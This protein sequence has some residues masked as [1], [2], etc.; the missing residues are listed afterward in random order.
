[1][2][3]VKKNM[4]SIIFLLIILLAIM[5]ISFAWMRVLKTGSNVSFIRA[6]DLGDGKI[7]LIDC[8]EDLTLQNAV[9]ISTKKGLAQEKYCKVEID[10][11]QNDVDLDY[12]IYLDDKDIEST[13]ERML[14]KYVRYSFV[15]DND[16]ETAEK[17]KLLS[18]TGSNP[19]RAI[20]TDT[21]N[22]KQKKVYNLKIWIDQDATNEVMNTIFSGKLRVEITQRRS[23]YLSIDPN[24]GTYKNSKSIISEKLNVGETKELETPVYEGYKFKGWEI[25][26]KT[27]TITNNTL[28][29]GIGSTT[30][31][32]KWDI[33]EEC[34]ARINNKYYITLEKALASA[35]DNDTITMIKNTT[36]SVRNTKNVTIDLNGF[37]ITGKDSTTITNDG[38]L[39]IIGTGKIENNTGVVIENKNDLTLGK[40]DG[41]VSITN[42]MLNGNIGIKQ[43]GTLN[44][45]DGII[46]ANVGISGPTTTKP[47]DYIVFVDHDNSSDKQKVYLINI[48]NT[49]A[50][51]MLDSVLYMNLQ[52]AINTAE[53]LNTKLPINIIRDCELAYTLTVKKDKNVVIDLDGNKIS[54]GYTITNNGNLTLKD[55]SSQRGVMKPSVTITNNGSLELNGIDLA[56]T[57]SANVIDNKNSLSIIN[58]NITGLDGYAINNS[59]SILNIDDAS[60][61]IANK[62]SL[63]NDYENL[64][65]KSGNIKG[66]YTNNSLTIDGGNIYND[67][68]Q[69]IYL[70]KGTLIVNDG[71]ISNTGTHK[72]ITSSYN[73]T[74]IKILGGNISSTGENTVEAQSTLEIYSGTIKNTNKDYS[75]IITYFSPKVY[76]YGGTIEAEGYGIRTGNVTVNGG[77][78]SGKICGASFEGGTS[79]INGGTI[80]SD[81]NAV[82][83]TYGSLTVNGGTLYG[84]QYG[85]SLEKSN[86]TLNLGIDDKNVNTTS[87]VVRGDTYGIYSSNAIFNYYDGII[88]GQ[89]APYYGQINAITDGYEIKNDLESIDGV[90]YQTSYLGKKQDFVSV[91]EETFNSLQKAID[92]VEDTAVLKII[93]EAS[94][95][96]SITIPETK[97]ITLDL[98]GNNISITQ[99]ITNN[100]K[101]IIKDS[102]SSGSLVSSS[103]DNSIISNGPLTIENGVIKRINQD[104]KKT[105]IKMNSGDFYLKDGVVISYGEVIHGN[106]NYPITI[107]GGTISEKGSSTAIYSEG[108]IKV[109]SGIITTDKGGYSIW[110]NNIEINGGTMNS[111]V[112]SNGDLTIND[113]E[114]TSSDTGIDC[115]GTTIINGGSIYGGKFG[116]ALN[117]SKAIITGGNITSDVTAIFARSRD[118]TISGGKIYGKKYGIDVYE[119]VINIGKDDS[120]INRDTPEI[121]GDVYG[122]YYESGKVN[123][124]DGI[125]K[126]KTEAY[127]GTINKTAEGY[128]LKDDTEDI[129]GTVYKTS[130]LDKQP[131]YV[132]VGEKQFNSLQDAI[133]SVQS[134]GTLEFISNAEIKSEITIP[135]DKNITLD[136]AGY[137]ANLTQIINN[138]GTFTIKDS[139]G[140]GKLV[141]Y[142][143]TDFIISKGNLYIESGTVQRT[144]NNSDKYIIDVENGTF[145]MKGGTVLAETKVSCIKIGKNVSSAKINGGTIR[146]L[147]GTAIY[148]SATIEV[149]D[150]YIISQFGGSTVFGSN[151]IINGGELTSNNNYTIYANNV[152]ITG[153]K[154]GVIRQG[155]AVTTSEFNMTGGLITAPVGIGGANN[156]ISGGKIDS[157]GTALDIN[158]GTLEVTDCEILGT[159]YGIKLNR[160]TLNIGKNDGNINSSLPLIKGNTYGVYITGGNFNFY[161]GIIKGKT[162]AYYGAISSLADNSIISADTE[163]IDDNTYIINYLKE[164]GNIIKNKDS[165][166]NNLQTAI[167]NAKSG[168][169]LQVLDNI[170]LHYPVTISKDD[171]ITIDLAGHNI[172]LMKQLNNLGQ[173]NI[174]S[175]QS[176]GNIKVLNSMESF[177]NNGN[178]QISNVELNN[179]LTKESLINN[180]ENASLNLDNVT[181][182]GK[183]GIKI[184]SNSNAV[185]NNTNT[186]LE[187]ANVYVSTGNLSLTGGT[188]ITKNGT[189][190]YQSGTDNKTIVSD[191]NIDA[192]AS[193]A[194]AISNNG[195]TD[196]ELT[197][198]DIKGPISSS[199]RNSNII[200]DNTTFSGKISVDSNSLVTLKNNSVIKT[201]SDHAIN[202]S[203]TLNLTNSKI[204]SDFSNIQNSGSIKIINNTGTINATNFDTD[205]Y[206]MNQD[207]YGIYN[208]KGTVNLNNYNLNITDNS[209]NRTLY[210]L[211]NTET[212]KINFLTGNI[213]LIGAKL[214]YGLYINN[215]E[216]VLGK[217]DGNVSTT[218][219]TV[220]AVGLTGIGS[221]K[222]N[223][224]LKFY[225]GKITGST[226]AKPETTTEIEYGY[227]VRNHIDDDGY[228]YCILEY[229]E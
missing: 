157:A 16:V 162:S 190:L 214:A 86:V 189:I 145:E 110:G 205:V 79:T 217:N 170:Y 216:I 23:Q 186:N 74:L 37:T 226:N 40:N 19:N 171:N 177:L 9:P 163:V 155:M 11:T 131:N 36:E 65:I 158:G 146:T 149:N 102:V 43:D 108:P 160:G 208:N 48:K 127:Y 135:E 96:T 193:Y 92:K 57:T 183:S 114:I 103:L 176:T 206:T 84:K 73:S 153:G 87:P 104:T 174:T 2:N 218:N 21:I 26:N 105:L 192:T 165:E 50:I 32:A 140:S 133:D 91:G 180:K 93:N 53:Q 39:E 182:N 1:M 64:S 63:Y 222:I 62:Y 10:N 125:F 144:D 61:I 4:R 6:K 191:T 49:A 195:T 223:G 200:L 68:Y 15:E 188:N 130:Y 54:T 126:G 88:K 97:T 45:Y 80:I 76:I 31:T 181:I 211:Y 141:G 209:S 111:T 225:D 122:L 17:T 100:G 147:Q 207:I 184:N 28:K 129:D 148:N 109:N 77:T 118:F 81:K 172:M 3:S 27:T 115:S 98:N 95:N 178:L 120:N 33:S 106:R 112:R 175:F 52:D 90:T 139:V 101:L 35:V 210:G 116:A 60:T 154:I 142:L 14:D 229:M 58:T 119:G 168:D 138:N 166:Y 72:A 221:K 204:I 179:T 199:G 164:Q 94:V 24:G 66:I 59:G 159:T 220:K 196:I 69:A 132:K 202:V 143:S 41:D 161:D 44:F 75:G 152:K 67:K 187:N 150:G 198:S 12:T 194:T 215:G 34:V 18:T 156:T 113:G 136:L 124:Y 137:T 228:E 47:D 117:S 151:V 82:Q 197:N 227:E 5:G 201:N 25:S 173:L 8:E 46:T 89:T 7:R 107:D 99:S 169:T 121:K 213:N 203:G 167:D 70:Y 71:N 13:E 55:S 56:E 51:A 123:F 219:P 78:I 85:I 38:N 224:Y 42:P 83:Q 212:G 30:I 29:M 128:I 134:E 20:A 22:Q 185:I